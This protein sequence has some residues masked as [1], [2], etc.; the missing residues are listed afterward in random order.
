MIAVT[1]ENERPQIT[2]RHGYRG[3]NV[4]AELIIL[5]GLKPTS[6]RIR[7]SE[8]G[9]DNVVKGLYRKGFKYIF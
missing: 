2:W 4:W 9:E 6:V 1:N 7:Y 5:S 3:D 8:T